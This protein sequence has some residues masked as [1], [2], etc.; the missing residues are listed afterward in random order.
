MM[1]CCHTRYALAATFSAFLFFRCAIGVAFPYAPPP[2]PTHAT[3]YRRRSCVA[4]RVTFTPHRLHLQA[5]VGL[6]GTCV[7]LR[8]VTFLRSDVSG[9]LPGFHVPTVPSYSPSVLRILPYPSAFLRSKHNT[10]SPVT[11]VRYGYLAVEVK[12]IARCAGISV[13]ARLLCAVSIIDS[14]TA[15]LFCCAYS[16]LLRIVCCTRDRSE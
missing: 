14:R 5:D 16:F 6:A 2:F 12:N 7:A 10:F 4:C 3:Y 15:H 13:I 9:T 8:M 11:L 1:R